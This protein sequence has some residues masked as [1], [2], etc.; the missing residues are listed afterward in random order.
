MA[1]SFQGCRVGH[2]RSDFAHMHLFTLNIPNSVTS[3][4]RKPWALTSE[5][6]SHIRIL[7][8]LFTGIINFCLKKHSAKKLLK[9]FQNHT[10]LEME[11]ALE[12]ICSA[13]SLR[14]YTHMHTHIQIQNLGSPFFFISPGPNNF[15]MRTTVIRENIRTKKRCQFSP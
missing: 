8:L 1:Y 4:Y 6:V 3:H 5:T 14:G 15:Q 9:Y 12:I 13:P 7:Y 10:I 11:C 2:D